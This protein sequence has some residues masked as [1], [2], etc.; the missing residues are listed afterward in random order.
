MRRFTPL[1][2]VGCV[3]ISATP[4]L[5]YPPKPQDWQALSAN[6]AAFLAAWV[7]FVSNY[8]PGGGKSLDEVQDDLASQMVSVNAAC[9]QIRDQIGSGMTFGPEQWT[10]GFAH[11]CWALASFQKAGS[12]N[13]ADKVCGETKDA[14]NFFTAFKP[15]KWPQDYPEAQDH[16]AQFTQANH[17]LR[18]VL[19]EAGAKQC[20]PLK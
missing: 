9:T 15:K 17:L 5:A 8:K 7:G 12:R 10:K 14:L 3:L 18:E 16:I 1:L 4:A 13:L 2:F 11:T 20:K 6:N 19:F